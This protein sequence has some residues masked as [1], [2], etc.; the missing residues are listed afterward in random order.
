MSY[1]GDSLYLQANGQYIGSPFSRIFEERED[2]DV[3]EVIDRV[4]SI[5]ES[6]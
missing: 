3:Q 1:V 2:F 5:I 6:S 4:A